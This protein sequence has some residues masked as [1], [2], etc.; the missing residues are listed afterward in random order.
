MQIN[1]VIYETLGGKTTSSIPIWFMRQA[2]RYLPEYHNVFNQ[3]KNFLDVCYTPRLAVEITLQPIRRFDFDAAIVFSDILVLPHALGANIKF[4][5]EVGPVIEPIKNSFFSYNPQQLLPLLSP[6]MDIIS[7]VRAKLSPTKAVIG[8][9]GAPWTVAA[10][11]IEGGSSKSFIKAREFAYKNRALFK[12]VIDTIVEATIFYLNKQYEAGADFLQ[13]FDSHAGVL[14]ADEFTE[15][16]IEP[17]KKIVQNLKGKLIGFPKGAG[18]MYK[19]YIKE[20]QVAGLG[21]DYSVPLDWIKTHLQPE[22][23]VQGNLN[24]FVL[25]YDLEKALIQTNNIINSLKDKPFIFN[26]GH[27]I[28]KTTP[29]EHVEKVVTL[30]KSFKR[31]L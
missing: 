5:K 29:I 23:T 9:A 18:V 31:Q 21:V 6:V 20:T 3:G 28:L 14:S 17:T 26:L 16:V 12:Q 8:F 4:I 15:W 22:I 7:T 30:V 27:G 24:P 25:A 11:L 10:Y 19:Q 1:S 13:L 2:G